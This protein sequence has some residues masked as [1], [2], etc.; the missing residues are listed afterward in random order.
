M[1]KILAVVIKIWGH[2]DFA[3]SLVIGKVLLLIWRLTPDPI[4]AIIE[5]IKEKIQSIKKEIKEK[6]KLLK[7]EINHFILSHF[8]VDISKNSAQI[9][10]LIKKIID[11]NYLLYIDKILNYIKDATRDFWLGFVFI[12]IN[13]ASFFSLCLITAVVVFVY[14]NDLLYNYKKSKGEYSEIHK[15]EPYDTKNPRPEYYRRNEKIYTFPAMN[16]PFYRNELRQ[17]NWVV[18]SVQS[19][20]Y[21]IINYIRTFAENI[22]DYMIAH[23]EVMDAD[24][25][26]TPE[27]RRVLKDKIRNEI[28][29]YIKNKKIRGQIDVVYINEILLDHFN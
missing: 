7:E 19:S 12:R 20:N 28:N 13:K 25:V 4:K 29:S 15:V 5:K 9:K 18:F 17:M 1:Q 16:L 27:G 22:K 10:D 26:N 14:S 24:F 8:K 3:L 21:F 23:L 6:I 2:V 11:Y